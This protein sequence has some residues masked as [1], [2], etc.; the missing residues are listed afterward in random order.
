MMEVLL[1]KKEV[2]EL[3]AEMKTYKLCS[4]RMFAKPLI[5]LSVLQ[6]GISGIL[7]RCRM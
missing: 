7:F 4:L 3:L 5:S 1:I 6:C 2:N